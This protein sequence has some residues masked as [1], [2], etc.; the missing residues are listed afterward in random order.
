MASPLTS[1]LTTYDGRGNPVRVTETSALFVLISV[2]AT[3][4]VVGYMLFLLN[5]S[6]RGDALP[7]SLVIIAESILI[8]QALLSMWTILSSGYEPR[9]FAYHEAKRVLMPHSDAGDDTVFLHGRPV[10]IDVFVTVYGEDI[11]T[12]RRTLRAAVERLIADRTSFDDGWSRALAEA[13][14][15]AVRLREG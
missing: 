10:L 13:W 1:N 6:N 9:T 11:G 4:G 2:V 12:V 7:Y 3:I 8:F 5:P 14:L 15:A